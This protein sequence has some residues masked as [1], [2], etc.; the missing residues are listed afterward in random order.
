MKNNSR[1]AASEIMH[2]WFQA[3]ID[4]DCSCVKNIFTEDAVYSEC[5]GP[6]YHG[7]QQIE[8]WFT[9]WHEKGNVLKWDIHRIMY[10]DGCAIAEWY[11]ECRYNNEVSGFNGATAADF[12]KDGKITKLC[13]YESKAEHTFPYGQQ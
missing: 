7:S 12:N 4:N 8:K 10:D 5:W 6:E 13:E 11:F 1:A 2:A 3:W 9:D